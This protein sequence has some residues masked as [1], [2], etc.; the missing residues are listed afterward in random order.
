MKTQTFKVTAVSLCVAGVLSLGACASDPYPSSRT[1]YSEP[2]S[3]SGRV[4]SNDSY[5]RGGVC[6]DCGT[7]R[8]ITEVNEGG[9]RSTGAGAVLGAI[10]GGVAGHQVGG[11]TGQDI[12]TAAGAVGGAIAGNE[13]EKNRRGNDVVYD[14]RVRMESG[15]ERVITVADT[16]GLRPG[17]EVIVDGNQITIVD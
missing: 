13:I 11:G 14:V 10:I 5:R 3:R 4:V 17:D 2:S 9:R 7:V 16:G 6:I 8:S 12:A 15:S 1:V